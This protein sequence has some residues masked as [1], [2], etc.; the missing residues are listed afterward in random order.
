MRTTLLSQSLLPADR[1]MNA[2]VSRPSARPIRSMMSLRLLAMVLLGGCGL[3][4]EE[5]ATATPKEVKAVSSRT[6]ESASTPKPHRVGRHQEFLKR[7]TSG[8]IDLLFLGDSITDHWPKNGATTWAKFAPWNPADFG[9]SAMRTEGL[10][11]NITNGE[12]D[13]LKP[14]A[15]VILIGINNILQ[16]YDEKPEWVA[17][18]ITKVVRTVQEKC[19]GSRI[20]LM[21]ILPGRWG[22]VNI[23]PKIA[24]VNQLIAKLDDGKSV[25]FRGEG[26]P[27]LPSGGKGDLIVTFQV[28]IPE[29]LTAKE[30]EFYEAIAKEKKL[31]EV[32]G[33]GILG[34]LF[35]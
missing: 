2:W 29:K 21:G 23:P 7:K 22:H 20:L 4:G 11:W 35:D 9:V 10:L 34:K 12:L 24:A 16:C 8:P 27:K 5:S 28:K 33:K 26:A 13:G 3:V 25:R 19:P 31:G 15:V 32:H 1:R 14:K 6:A 17:A 18:A 30:R